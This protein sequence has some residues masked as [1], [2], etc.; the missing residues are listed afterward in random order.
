MSTPAENL[1]RSLELLKSLQVQGRVAIRSTDLTR[2]HRQRLVKNGFLIEVMKGW[3]YPSNPLLQP[4][5]T[6][7]WFISYWDFCSQYLTHRFGDDWTLSPEGSLL[8]QTGN[9]HV[10]QQLIVRSPMASNNIQALLHKTSILGLKAKVD[11]TLIEKVEGVNVLKL[12]NALIMCAPSFF[13]NNELDCRAA[14][15]AIRSPSE[16]LSPLLDGGHSLVASRLAAAYENIGRKAFSEQIV[17]TMQAAGYNLRLEDPFAGPTTLAL[18]PDEFSPAVNRLRLL[19][20]SMR[21]EVIDRFPQAPQSKGKRSEVLATIDEKYSSDAYHSLSIE[22]YQVSERLI[23]HVRSGDWNPD[24]R[25]A[26]KEQQN[27]LVARGYWLTFQRVRKSIERVFE[28]QEVSQL[29][30]S[31]LSDWYLQLFSPAVTA[32]LIEAHDLAG[33]RNNQVYIR[34][35]YHV[36]PSCENVRLLMPAFFRLLKEEPNPAV[37]AVLGHFCFVYIHPYPDGNGR[38]GRFLM[39]LCLV[40]AGYPWIIVKEKR[41]D[42]YFAALEKASIENEIGPFVDF[43]LEH[44]SEETD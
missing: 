19:W 25:A 7:S 23:N 26:D 9:R 18:A 17:K 38:L 11:K 15:A 31:D 16:L 22:G 28:G 34:G 20:Q 13:R 3:Y 27:A 42:R 24:G 37:R 30:A 6:T 2:V 8:W 40:A 41:R 39:N 33:Y 4:G 44:L 43:L 29:I 32:G 5:E 12:P 35:S 1:A 14:L 10:P 36:P 21:Q